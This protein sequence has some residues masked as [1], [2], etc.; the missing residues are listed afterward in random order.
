MCRMLGVVC[1][2]EDL[3]NCAIYEVRE[4]LKL[5]S[6]EN[7]SGIGIGTYQ[8]DDPLLKKRPGIKAGEIDYN[9]LLAGLASNV[10]LLHVGHPTD[11]AWK[12]TNTHPF[13]FRR[14]LFAGIGSFSGIERHR[15]DLLTKLPPFLS[16]NV[17]GESDIEV[18]FHLLLNR[19]FKEGTLNDLAISAVGLGDHVRAFIEEAD[20]LQHDPRQVASFAL[21]ATNGQVMAAACRGMTMHYSHREGILECTHSEA[22]GHE[23]QSHRR[24]KGIMLGADMSAPG[25]QWRE[26][27]SG[28]LLSISK[29]LELRVEPL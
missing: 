21:I 15:E 16:R 17:Q 28:S 13:R 6:G 1:N 7:Y 9:S 19:L 12:E 22:T 14:W 11:A 8:N 27:A 5:R 20:A 26:V 18:A 2:D 29:E 24:F 25:H 3:L 4:A 10:L 23:Q